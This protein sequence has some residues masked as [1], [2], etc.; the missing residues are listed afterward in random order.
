[1]KPFFFFFL[2]MQNTSYLLCVFGH[3]FK[4]LSMCY[5]LGPKLGASETEMN[6]TQSLKLRGE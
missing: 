5:L 1:M 6:K 2:Q 4:N 3:L